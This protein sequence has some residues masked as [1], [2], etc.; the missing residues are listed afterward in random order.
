MISRQ[1]RIS[2]LQSKLML[3]G[4]SG[5]AYTTEWNIIAKKLNKLKEENK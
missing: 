4:F 3:L 2:V 1:E 5:M